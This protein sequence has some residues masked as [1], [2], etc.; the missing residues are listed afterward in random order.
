MLTCFAWRPCFSFDPA[1]DD[2]SRHSAVCRKNNSKKRVWAASFH[3]V[4]VAVD[5]HAGC[6]P[7]DNSKYLALCPTFYI[8]SSS[9]DLSCHRRNRYTARPKS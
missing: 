3:T 8:L 6:Q 9:R 5:G 2:Q 4:A 7:E 1:A